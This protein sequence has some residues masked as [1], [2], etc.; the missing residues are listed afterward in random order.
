MSFFDGLDFLY[1]G[2]FG[3]TIVNT[4]RI[5]ALESLDNDFCLGCQFGVTNDPLFNRKTNSFFLNAYVNGVKNRA[6]DDFCDDEVVNEDSVK[7]KSKESKYQGEDGVIREPIM[8]FDLGAAILR[9]VL[10]ME[11]RDEERRG[12]G[13]GFSTSIFSNP[14][15]VAFCD[16]I[17]DELIRKDN[18]LVILKDHYQNIKRKNKSV[19]SFCVSFGLKP[20]V[21]LSPLGGGY[22]VS[23]HLE[24]LG[25]KLKE[26]F[27]LV[28]NRASFSYIV[29]YFWVIMRGADGTPYIHIN[30]YVNNDRF[31]QRLAE[32]INSVWLKV[33]NGT[34][35]IVHYSHRLKFNILG[36]TNVFIDHLGLDYSIFDKIDKETH[37]IPIKKASKFDNHDIT[38]ENPVYIFDLNGKKSTKIKH[39]A[40]AQNKDMFIQYLRCIAM[41]TFNYPGKRAFGLSK[42]REKKVKPGKFP[43]K[44]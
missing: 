8:K 14:T 42:V 26:F 38:W 27:N 6:G 37:L 7:E 29:G 30:F 12:K 40:N 28:R 13:N 1:P 25:N 39:F 18:F 34:G 41:E 3:D 10:I 22:S 23:V 43:K 24:R 2:E 5:D 4:V 33:S 15:I 21:K 20:T 16:I 31:G 35:S 32:D 36:M 11:G 44:V 9:E 19:S 17:K